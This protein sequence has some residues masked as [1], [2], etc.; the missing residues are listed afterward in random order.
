LVYLIT[1][2]SYIFNSK[3][4]NR[5]FGYTTIVLCL[6]MYTVS[7]NRKLTEKL[8]LYKTTAIPAFQSDR[9]QNGDLYGM[10]YL[11]YFRKHRDTKDTIQPIVC[12][13]DHKI[14][15]YTICD[16]YLWGFFASEKFYC[17]VNKLTIVKIN[18]GRGLKVRLDSSKINVLLFELSERNIRGTLGKPSSADDLISAQDGP[19]TT[20]NSAEALTPGNAKKGSTSWKFKVRTV[21][22]RMKNVRSDVFDFIFNNKI[23]SNIESNFWEISL[24]TPIKEFKSNINYKLF[25]KVDN[26]VKVSKDGKQLFYTPTIDTSDW[27]S[28]FRSLSE[29]EKD[30]LIRRFNRIYVKGKSLGFDKIYLSIIPNPVSILDPHYGG[31]AYNDIVNRIQN[32]KNLKIPY[33]DVVP[34]FE[35]LKSQAYSP[36]DTHWSQYGAHTWLNKFNIELNK[37]AIENSDAIKR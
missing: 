3:S 19:R 4:M 29:T 36:S 11:P 35:V 37:I 20:T 34:T 2:N 31:L 17:N 33:I 28:S 8:F 30:S 12:G 22:E 7:C 21:L 9:W 32:D 6:V 27:M 13:P 23:N 26:N 14:D 25:N 1:G 24:F 5:Y 10:S 16:S 15:L 18:D